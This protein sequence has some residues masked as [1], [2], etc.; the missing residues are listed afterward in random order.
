MGL[1]AEFNTQDFGYPEELGYGISADYSAGCQAFIE[2]F[3]AAAR[4]VVPV[5]TGNLMASIQGVNGEDSVMLYTNCGYAQYVEY[6]TWKS[7]AQP[8]F[9]QALG[10]ALEVASAIWDRELESGLDR[11][12]VE[13]QMEGEEIRQE[14]R[15]KGDDIRA[16][17]YRL[18][19]QLY[20]QK[21]Q[22]GREVCARMEAEGSAPDAVQEQWEQYVQWAEEVRSETQAEG[23]GLRDLFYGIGDQMADIFLSIQEL[24]IAMMEMLPHPY[25]P[26]TLII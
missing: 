15:G 14:W 3:L 6:G 22:E 13:A 20:E 19:E 12:M 11:V 23:D 2:T 5:R 16:E 10:S 17:M 18:A 21:L 9:E 8:Y 4:A 25:I 24:F 7:P 1:Y 26:E